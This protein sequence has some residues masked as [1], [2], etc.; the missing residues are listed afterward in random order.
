MNLLTELNND[1]LNV[2]IISEEEYNQLDEGAQRTY[3]RVGNNITQYYRCTSGPKKGKL[4]SDPSKCGQRK[5]PRRVRHGRQVAQRKGSIRVRKTQA[6]KR[7]QISKR[8]TALNNV[9][10]QRREQKEPTQTRE[11]FTEYMNYATLL[12]FMLKQPSVQQALLA[13]SDEL[14]EQHLKLIDFDK[15]ISEGLS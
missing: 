1:E 9:L 10:R 8:V 12:E 14:F 11:S 13:E 6:R 4:A 15:L 5:D 7:T 3:R 2:H